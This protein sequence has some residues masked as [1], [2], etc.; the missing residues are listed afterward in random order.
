MKTAEV[1]KLSMKELRKIV[2]KM[3]DVSREKLDKVIHEGWDDRCGMAEYA[4]EKHTLETILKF[5]D[6][7]DYA[8]DYASSMV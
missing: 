8:R 7:P 6:D 2:A 5:I 1:K 3:A 4:S